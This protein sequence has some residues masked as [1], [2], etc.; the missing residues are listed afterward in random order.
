[1][2]RRPAWS[3]RN[4]STAFWAWQPVLRLVPDDALG[5]V[6]HVGGDLLAAVGRQAVQHD[7]VVLGVTQQLAVTV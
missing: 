1:M 7:H 2:S 3:I 4:A 5:T 6:D